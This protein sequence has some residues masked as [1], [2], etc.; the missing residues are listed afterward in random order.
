MSKRAPKAKANP[1]QR[2]AQQSAPSSM[3]AALAM[4][5]SIH[6]SGVLSGAG[7]IVRTAIIQVIPPEPELSGSPRGGGGCGWAAS[8]RA[9]TTANLE[10]HHAGHH[11]GHR[12]YSSAK[13]EKEL[14]MANLIPA[15]T[16]QPRA[17]MQARPT[18]SRRS[19]STSLQLRCIWR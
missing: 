9:K 19:A 13:D 2:A 1:W 10:E 4:A 7:P 3:L 18:E 11:R 12:A 14:A 8:Q 16:E 6:S 15:N 17:S 5:A